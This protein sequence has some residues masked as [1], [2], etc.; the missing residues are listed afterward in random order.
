MQALEELVERRDPLKKAERALS[1]M[2]D[3][4]VVA[5]EE[6]ALKQEDASDLTSPLQDISVFPALKQFGSKYTRIRIPAR[7]KHQV[8]QRDQGSCTH[9]FSDGSYC[10]SRMMLE[11]DHIVPVA[12]GGQNNLENLTLRCRCHNAWRAIQEF[13]KE[14]MDQFRN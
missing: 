12:R 4:S 11:I 10:S 8:W 3:E 1:K 5:Q 2:G 9:Q 7:I 6:T 14:H 13:G